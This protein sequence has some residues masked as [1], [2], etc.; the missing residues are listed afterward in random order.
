MTL[1]KSVYLPGVLPSLVNFCA[2]AS[3][4][5]WFT[6]Q[7][8]RMSPYPLAFKAS[9][10][11]WPPQPTSAMLGRSFGLGRPGVLVAASAAKA[12]F[13]W[14]THNGNPAAAAAIEH[15]AR[16]ERREMWNGFSDNG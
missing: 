14:T 8:A 11:P 16:N 12:A 5:S 13:L 6:S 10:V 2:A 15:W 4:C 9:Y 1:R 7:T 3:R